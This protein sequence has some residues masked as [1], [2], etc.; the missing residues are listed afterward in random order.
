MW[1]KRNVVV[2]QTQSDSVCLQ[3]EQCIEEA[4]TTYDSAGEED[5]D[6]SSDGIP[7]TGSEL[8]FYLSGL[9][10]LKHRR[11]PFPELGV[12]IVDGTY[13]NAVCDAVLKDWIF[14]DFP[15][16]IFSVDVWTAIQGYL[17]WLSGF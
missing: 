14:L 5:E 13:N 6:R 7:T 17:K 12:D 9:N 11:V 15:I 1:L 8:D 16:I 4:V 10:F 3:V 2:S